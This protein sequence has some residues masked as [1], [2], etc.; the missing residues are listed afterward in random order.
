MNYSLIINIR[1]TYLYFNAEENVFKAPLY[2]NVN[3][4]KPMG[5]GVGREILFLFLLKCV[6]IWNKIAMEYGTLKYPE[7]K[8]KHLFFKKKMNL[9]RYLFS[10]RSLFGQTIN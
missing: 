10:G 4:P 2:N 3:L 1:K 7:I 8:K 5:V 9:N 6:K